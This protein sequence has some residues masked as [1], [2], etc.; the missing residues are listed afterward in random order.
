V[1]AAAAPGL[2][3]SQQT[4]DWQAGFDWWR[5]ECERNLSKFSCAGSIYIAVATQAGRTIDEDFPGGGYVFNPA[6]EL[7][8]ATPDWTEGV[9][10]AEV[11]I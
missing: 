10:Y 2:H 1:L 4:R 5:G 9:L 11:D 3:G 6:G 8:A 7:I